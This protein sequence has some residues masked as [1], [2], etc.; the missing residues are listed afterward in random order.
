MFSISQ[1][2]RDEILLN[3]ISK[4]LDCGNVRRINTRKD[5]AEL[6]VYKF[7]DIKEKIIPFL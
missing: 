1:H 3:I 6:V 4:H 5:H 2:S 7:H